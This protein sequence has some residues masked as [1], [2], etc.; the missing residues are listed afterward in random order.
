LIRSGN[1]SAAVNSFKHAMGLES[2][3]V[4]YAYLYFLALDSIGATAQ[5]VSELKLKI[6]TYNNAVQLKNLGMS[7]TQK[8]Q[9]AEGYQFFKQLK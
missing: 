8:L 5:A 3:N 7:F 1:K 6:S 4:Q 2:N 9:N